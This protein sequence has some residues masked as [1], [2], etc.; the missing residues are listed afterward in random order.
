MINNVESYD[1]VD[2]NEKWTVIDETTPS[3]NMECLKSIN[4]Y[5]SK[6]NSRPLKLDENL[7]NFAKKRCEQVS[8]F[9][10]IDDGRTDD[11][12]SIGENLLRLYDKS[13]CSFVIGY[14]YRLTNFYDYESNNPLE[15]LS[16]Q[17]KIQMKQ[18]TQLVWDFTNRVGCAQCDSDKPPR[19]RNVVCEFTPAGNV[20]G[21]FKAN[22]ARPHN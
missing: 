20:N 19:G 12:I 11:I 13:N 5:R 21:L 6:H 17:Q 14:W 16:D 10:K 3:F 9:E 2:P 18:F 4:Y 8:K 22:V 7:I 1:Y 15:N